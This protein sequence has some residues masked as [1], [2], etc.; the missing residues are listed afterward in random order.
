VPSSYCVTI[1]RS[2]SGEPPA[3]GTP[4]YHTP[5]LYPV[6]GTPNFT[7][8]AQDGLAS[9]NATEVFENSVIGPTGPLFERVVASF[10]E[11]CPGTLDTEAEGT[12]GLMTPQEAL[13]YE[14]SDSCVD[15]LINF[16]VC[17]ATDLKAVR[18][19]C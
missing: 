4:P 10:I 11:A 9:C 14:C 15:W 17:I 13:K 3:T 5:E 2:V 18:Y 16:G 12:G 6:S 1:S 8:V 19:P 7:A